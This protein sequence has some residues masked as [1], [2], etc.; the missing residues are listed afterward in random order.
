M[1]HKRAKLSTRQNERTKHGTDLPP[2]GGV[3]LAQESVPKSMAR[4]L[5]AEGVRNAYKEK[6]SRNDDTGEP[7]IGERVAKR[8]KKKETGDVKKPSEIKHGESLA[9]YNQRVEEEMRIP[10]SEAMQASRETAK[11]A[12]KVDAQTAKAARA[13]ANKPKATQPVPKKDA[14]PPPDGATPNLKPGRKTEFDR[15]TTRTRLN[16][17]VQAPPTLTK[18]PRGA[19][20]RTAPGSVGTGAGNPEVV[21]MA[22]KQMMEQERERAIKRYRELKES[23][24]VT[25]A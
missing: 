3:S 15:N 14:P 17:I 24:F 8:R 7:E 23:R 4:V 10:V 5:Q 13:A 6:R 12:R 19:P 9:Q 2:T 25:N 21:S 22:Q 18:L 11:R 20:K 16:D 1:P